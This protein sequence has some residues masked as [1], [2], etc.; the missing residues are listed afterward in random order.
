MAGVPLLANKGTAAS[1]P[2]HMLE[3]EKARLDQH[4]RRPEAG[5]GWLRETRGRHERSR[6]PVDVLDNPTSAAANAG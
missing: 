5:T 6:L 2:R 1:L 3:K 4:Y